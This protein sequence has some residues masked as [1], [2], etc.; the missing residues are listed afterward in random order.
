MTSSDLPNEITH[1]IEAK[2]PH[3]HA[4]VS[5]TGPGHYVLNVNAPIFESLS[6][7]KQQQ[8]VYS[9]I[10]DLMAGNDAP[11]H[12]IDKMNLSSSLPLSK[13][14]F[15]TQ[16]NNDEDVSFDDT[17]RVIADNYHYTEAEFSNGSGQDKLINAAGTNEGS[18][19]IFAFAQLEQ[20]TQAQTLALFGD[21]YR[22]DVLKD[23]SG[24]GHQNIRNF[25]LS[26]WDGI[27]FN[28]PALTAK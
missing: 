2:I 13:H 10:T 18:C 15:L 28:T 23:L 11:V 27:H 19:K 12:A 7:V 3:S 16:I 5:C 26:G 21:F 6:M 14:D 25:M 1:R 17:M 20:L 8:L 24:T 22:K 9:A 4:Q